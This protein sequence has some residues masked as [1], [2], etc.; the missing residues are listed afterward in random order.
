VDGKQMTIV[1]YVDDL[2][3]SHVDPSV[4]GNMIDVLKAEFGQKLDFT[5]RRGKIH[6]YLGLRLDFS[7][8]GKVVMT[9]SELLKETPEDL[10]KGPAR[11]AA[12]NYLFHVNPKAKK[13]DNDAAVLYHH[14]T[15]KLLYLSKRT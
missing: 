14:L 6:E 3:I 7:N 15:A 11:S 5:V 4:V 8:K 10:F 13:L 2:K 1:W 12:S 9:I